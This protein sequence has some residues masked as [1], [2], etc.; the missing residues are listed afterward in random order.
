MD[1]GATFLD[2]P[3]YLDQHGMARCGLPAVVEYRYPI[4][5]TEGMLDGAKIRCP[6][7]HWFLGPVDALAMPER[8]KAAVRAV[9]R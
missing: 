7:G 6:R 3:A 9:A 4:R 5:S 2:C 1:T 8:S